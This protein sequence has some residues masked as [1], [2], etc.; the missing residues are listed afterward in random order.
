MTNFVFLSLIASY[1]FQSIV[2]Q[3]TQAPIMLNWRKFRNDT[4]FFKLFSIT[5][6]YTESEFNK[7]DN[8]YLM[9][10]RNRTKDGNFLS[11]DNDSLCDQER[12]K[13]IFMLCPFSSDWSR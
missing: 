2:N 5:W 10:Q 11:V 7:G 13:L 1:S 12:R 3:L 9:K 6:K 4:N 8:Y